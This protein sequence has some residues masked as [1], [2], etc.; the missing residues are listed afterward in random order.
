VAI[1]P[2]VLS[3]CAAGSQAQQGSQGQQVS[4][5]S[6]PTFQVTSRL[7]FLDVTVLD[8]KGQPVVTGLTKDD[9]KITEDKKPQ[10]IFPSRHRRRTR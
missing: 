4:Q 3:A 6:T 8:K 1:L 10:R 9:F 7:V 5:S 2:L